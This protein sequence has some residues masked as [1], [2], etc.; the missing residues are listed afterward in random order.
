MSVNINHQLEQINNLKITTVGSGASVGAAGIV[1]YYGDGSQLSGTGSGGGG[2]TVQ[3]EG[4]SLS[5][6]GTTLN[7]VGNGVAATGTGAT[8]TITISGGGGGGSSILTT[9]AFLNS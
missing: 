8:K 9:L 4:V 5:T 7:F 2:V 6:T 3:D 1:T